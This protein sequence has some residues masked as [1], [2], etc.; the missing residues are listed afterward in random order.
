V[1]GINAKRLKQFAVRQLGLDTYLC[2]PGDGRQQPQ[3]PAAAMLWALLI[4]QILRRSSYHGV[5]E[6]VRSRGRRNL[7]VGRR[8]GDDSLGC[9]TER[10]DTDNL[11]AAVGKAI[12]RAK[13]NKAFENSRWIGLA[14]DGTGSGHVNATEAGCPLCHP[15]LNGDNEVIGQLHHFSMVSVVGTGLSL[16]VDVEL[17]RRPT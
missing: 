10:L 12:R 2:N 11:R 16:P 4:R 17:W 7:A 6:L 5:E 1:K 15:V 3:I 13:R 8:F 14:L 9:L